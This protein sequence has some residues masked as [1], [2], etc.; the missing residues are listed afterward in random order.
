MP[1]CSDDMGHRHLHRVESI[2]DYSWN[3]LALEQG[4]QTQFA[5]ERANCLC[6]SLRGQHSHLAGESHASIFEEMISRR[7]LV[8]QPIHSGYQVQSHPVHRDSI[9]QWCLEF[10]GLARQSVLHLFP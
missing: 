3:V 2:F 1:I 5:S 10:V 7:P 6:K 9:L 4:L 8:R